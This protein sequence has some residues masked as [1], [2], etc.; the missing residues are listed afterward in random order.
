VRPVAPYCFSGKDD[1]QAPPAKPKSKGGRP[2]DV[3]PAE[4]IAKIR[5]KGGSVSGNLIDIGSA[6]GP[7]RARTG[8]WVS[9]ATWG[10][11]RCRRARA[12]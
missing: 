5:A 3:L 1:D 12:D 7:R 6:A 11:S 10:W 9:C 8:Y 2:R 4:A